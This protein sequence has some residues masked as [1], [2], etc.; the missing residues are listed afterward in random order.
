MISKMDR[1]V[2]LENLQSRRKVRHDGKRLLF[3]LFDC[4]AEVTLKQT[5]GLAV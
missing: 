5:N 3:Q 1:P 2:Q 4:S